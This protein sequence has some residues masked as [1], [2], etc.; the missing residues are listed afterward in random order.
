M[1]ANVLFFM[2]FSVSYC[3]LPVWYVEQAPVFVRWL[4]FNGFLAVALWLLFQKR[5]SDRNISLGL[6]HSFK[7]FLPLIA[8]VAAL[9]LFFWNLPVPS[10]GDNQSHIGPAAVAI[11]KAGKFVNIPLF[12]IVLWIIAV[13]LFASFMFKQKNKDISL[14][15]LRHF[16]KITIAAIF[17]TGNIYFALISHYKVISHLGMWETMLRYPPIGKIIYLAGFLFFGIHEFVPRV[18]QFAFIIAVAFFLIKTLKVFYCAVPEKI[19]FMLFLLFPSFFYFSNYSLLTC[20]VVFFYSAASYYFLKASETEDEKYLVKLALVLS[21][22]MLYKRLLLGFIPVAFCYLL[23]FPHGKDFNKDAAFYFALALICGLPFTILS[24]LLGVRNAGGLIS[25]MFF[26]NLKLLSVTIGW[27]LFFG[28]VAGFFWEIHSRFSR[29]SIFFCVLFAAYYIMISQTE[30]NGYIRHAQPFY[31]PVFY[32]IAVFLCRLRVSGK[33]KIFP[34]V[35]AV[36]IATSAYY[37]FLK[38]ILTKN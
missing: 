8:P 12:R 29:S 33:R 2:L 18:I 14:D 25:S 16:K 22:G 21:V 24:G 7:R 27:V 11:A 6:P 17:F 19:I 34:L 35:S 37:S 38:Y 13:G 30:A 1:P 4:M 10:G 31:L 20:G 5:L 23:I 9:H 36:L 32:F 28:A 3:V 15:F 26:I